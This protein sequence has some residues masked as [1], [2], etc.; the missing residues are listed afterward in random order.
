M[1]SISSDDEQ[2]YAFTKFWE[3]SSKVDTP[4]LWQA[5]AHF[6][7]LQQNRSPERKL[8][9]VKGVPVIYP[10]KTGS[11]KP[12]VVEEALSALMDGI[13]AQ[14]A[15]RAGFGSVSYVKS[16]GYNP[17]VP[18][19]LR[20]SNSAFKTLGRGTTMKFDVTRALRFFIHW[21]DENDKYDGRVDLDLSAMILD[22]DF[23]SIEDITYY[24][25]RGSTA[26]HSGDITSAPNGA[27]EFIDVDI[28]K[29]RAQKNGAKYVLMTVN[30]YTQQK[31]SDLTETLAGFMSRESLMSGEIY[32]PATVE[33]SFSVHNPTTMVAPILFDITTGEAVWLDFA[34]HGSKLLNNVGAVAGNIRDLLKT[35]SGMYKVTVDDVIKANIEA[36]GAYLP[37]DRADAADTIIRL[38]NDDTNTV[39]F[40]EILT[41]WL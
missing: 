10:N 6:R 23:I 20:S 9:F 21:K 33:N 8:V 27:S 2:E 5:Y 4:V 12:A 16:E 11:L 29:L 34:V 19:G 39:H 41:K 30:S 26:A 38:T 37:A 28:P 32:E 3:V 24:N 14:Y 13:V 7:T 1:L 35:Y 17:T 22:R 18:F 36:R 31:F 25:L 15:D 40:D